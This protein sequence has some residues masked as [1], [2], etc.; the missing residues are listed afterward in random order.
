MKKEYMKPATLV[1]ELQYKTHLLIGS[2]AKSLGLSGFDDEEDE[3]DLSDQGGG[4][5]LW[6]R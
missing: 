1:E 6:D 3:L 2:G 4:S 5:N